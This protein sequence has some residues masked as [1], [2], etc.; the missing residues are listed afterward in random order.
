MKLNKNL[1]LGIIVAILGVIIESLLFQT[2][3]INI[4]NILID[5]IAGSL[6][7]FIASKIL[8]NKL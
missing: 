8:K 7:S 1:K 2:I 3:S 4:Q 5:F 6:A